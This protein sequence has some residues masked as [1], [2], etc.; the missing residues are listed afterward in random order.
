[1]AHLLAEVGGFDQVFDFRAR[2]PCRAGVVVRETPNER[3]G[4]R[5]V[6]LQLLLVDLVEGVR[7]GVVIK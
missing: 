7:L 1:M 5:R 2:M 4:D 6:Q 3:R